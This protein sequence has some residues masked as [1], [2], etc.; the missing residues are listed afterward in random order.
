L[1]SAGL[2]QSWFYYSV[3]WSLLGNCAQRRH[4]RGG[5]RLG[6]RPLL[7]KNVVPGTCTQAR[8]R[9]GNDFSVGGAKNWTT[10]RLAKQLLVKNNHDNQ[11]QSTTLCNT[12]VYFLKK[13][14]AVYNGV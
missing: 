2:T 3:M 11:I 8:H 4:G 13:V 12:G 7:W 14:Y 6:G 10:F 9:H 5:R 1:S